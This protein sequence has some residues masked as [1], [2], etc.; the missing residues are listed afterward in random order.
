MKYRVRERERGSLLLLGIV[1]VVVVVESR[2]L[3]Q[4]LKL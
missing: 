1:T 4:T 3:S 2:Y